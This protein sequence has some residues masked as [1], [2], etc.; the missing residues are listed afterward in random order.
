MTYVRKLINHHTIIC[1]RIINELSL[2]IN[3][4]TDWIALGYR[5]SVHNRSKLLCNYCLY[6]VAKVS[7][8]VKHIEDDHPEHLST[9][10]YEFISHVYI[11]YIH[12]EY[13][14][15]NCKLLPIS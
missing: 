14:M 11:C 8:M 1:V 6:S 2:V 12:L 13:I 5:R 9:S 15:T 10:K 3:F 7:T 4:L